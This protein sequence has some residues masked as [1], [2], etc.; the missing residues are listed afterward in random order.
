[1]HHG[2]PMVEKGWINKRYVCET[3][4]YVTYMLNMS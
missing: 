1:M 4:G 3:C 2:V